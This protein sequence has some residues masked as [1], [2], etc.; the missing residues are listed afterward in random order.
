MS[1]LTSEISYPAEQ[2]AYAERVKRIVCADGRIPKAQV[3]TYGCQQ[4]VSD[5][6][7]LK[8][9]LSLMGYE[10]TENQEEADFIIFNTCAVRE[11]AEDRVFG[12]VGATKNL[13]RKTKICSLRFAGVWHNNNRLQ[14]GLKKVIPMWI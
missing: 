14:T 12:N 8:G 7:R 4:N 5:S 1:L 6:Q 13:K 10:I 9:M 11:H 3:V 2:Q